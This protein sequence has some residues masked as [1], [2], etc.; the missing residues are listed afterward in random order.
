MTKLTQN[1]ISF[2]TLVLEIMKSPQENLTR[3]RVSNDIK[4]ITRV[5]EHGRIQSGR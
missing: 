4:S 1:T 2:L 3:Q 5:P